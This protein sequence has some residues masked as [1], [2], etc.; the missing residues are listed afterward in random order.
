[1]SKI[2]LANSYTVDDIRRR[3]RTG[4]LYVRD[5]VIEE[6]SKRIVEAAENN[7][8]SVRVSFDEEVFEKYNI[9][10]NV[11]RSVRNHFETLRFEVILSKFR[12]RISIRW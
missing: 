3:A 10:D 4:R 8:N 12:K 11:M 9:D 7:F 2:S 1:M 6:I 5:K